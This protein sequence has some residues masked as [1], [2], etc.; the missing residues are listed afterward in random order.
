MGL[1]DQLPQFGNSQEQKLEAN[2]HMI[3][4]PNLLVLEET[5]LKHHFSFDRL[6]RNTS[7]NIQ[8]WQ[9]FEGKEYFHAFLLIIRNTTVCLGSWLAI[10]LILHIASIPEIPLLKIYCTKTNVWVIK[11]CIWRCC[12][13]M[14]KMA[15]TKARNVPDVDPSKKS[16]TKLS[17]F[18]LWDI[19][20]L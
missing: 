18:I 8:V 5:K 13:S 20:Q 6:K 11:M 16:W 15:K 3:R 4:S 14:F 10:F 9:R 12:W 7:V 19:M 17:T 2:K 1:D